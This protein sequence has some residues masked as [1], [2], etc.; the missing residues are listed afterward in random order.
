[1]KKTTPTLPEL[2]QIWMRIRN[3]MNVMES[4]PRNFGV[5]G[6]LFLSEIHTIQAIGTAPENNVRIIAEMMGVTPSAASQVITKLS[7]RGLVSKIRGVKNEKEVSLELTEKGR[8]A[9]QTHEAI[10]RHVET[11]ITERIGD[12]TREERNTLARVFSAFES[13][14][15]ERIGELTGA[16]RTGT[17]SA[18]AIRP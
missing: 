6:T 1:M 4:I 13:V 8:I 16:G 14:Y 11:L 3:K 17:R 7:K 10:H 9:F 15:D 12:L 5:E 18:E 2:Y